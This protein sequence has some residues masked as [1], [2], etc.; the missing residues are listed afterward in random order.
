MDIFWTPIDGS[1]PNEVL[2]SAPLVQW[3]SSWSPDGRLL[4]FT[5]MHPTTGYDIWLLPLESDRK[6]QPFLHT[7]F[8]ERQVSFSPDGHWLTYTSDESGRDEIYVREFPGS[9][10]KW[11]ISTEGGS[12][13]V[14]SPTGQELFYRSSDKMMVVSIMMHPTFTAGRPSILFEANYERGIW[15]LPYYDV[16]PDGQHFVMIKETEAEAREINVVL[17]WFEELKHLSPRPES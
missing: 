16:S 7:S 10:Q 1:G 4:V 13:P 12:D 2:L 3:P 8:D 5:E 11:Q 6:P 15:A 9:G 14:W 17:N